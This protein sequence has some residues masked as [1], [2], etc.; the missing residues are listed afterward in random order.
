MRIRYFTAKS[1]SVILLTSK[2]A[3][4]TR[5]RKLKKIKRRLAYMNFNILSKPAII[6]GEDKIYT[7]PDELNNRNLKRAMLVVTPHFVNNGLAA[8]LQGKLKEAGIE[9]VVYSNG[10]KAMRSLRLYCSKRKRR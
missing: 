3:F 4:E 8:K 5:A 10:G 7:L 6:F 9:S 2:N 1:K